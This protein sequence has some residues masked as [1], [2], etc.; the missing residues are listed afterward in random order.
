[1]AIA[2]LA[3]FA[4]LFTTRSGWGLRNSQMGWVGIPVAL[5]G[6]LILT[7]PDE[8]LALTAAVVLIVWI[9]WAL[10]TLLGR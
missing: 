6:G 3:F 9:V 7:Y 1:M 10:K 4:L 2:G 8:A 5:L